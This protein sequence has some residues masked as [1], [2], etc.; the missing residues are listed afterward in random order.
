VAVLRMRAVTD[1]VVLGKYTSRLK[2]MFR[3]TL[4]S[5][6]KPGYWVNPATGER[7]VMAEG[8]FKSLRSAQ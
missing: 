4:L 5:K 8:E 1:M 7:D 2:P 3:R 6:V